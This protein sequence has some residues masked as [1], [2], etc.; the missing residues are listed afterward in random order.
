M[1]NFGKQQAAPT[2]QAAPAQGE[3]ATPPTLDAEGKPIEPAPA[4]K[5]AP[6]YEEITTLDQL[7]FLGQ[8]NENGEGSSAPKALDT[9]KLLT[10]EALGNIASSIDFSSNM[11]PEL[12]DRVKAGD[13]SS[14]FEALQYVGQNAYT[15]SMMHGGLVASKALQSN[16][17]VQSSNLHGQI[18][19]AIN[20]KQ[21]LAAIPGSDNP[22][23]ANA[24]ANLSKQ[25]KAQYP[26]AT[27]DQV[28]MMTQQ[29]FQQLSNAMNP[30]AP[31][32]DPNAPKAKNW[33]E[34][35]GLD[36]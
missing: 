12:V 1:F 21:V 20:D 16:L 18:D 15:Q 28:A 25:V 34:F 31:N 26:N 3:P 23:V 29:S 4:T 14:F 8:N 10:P 2:N 33:L 7:S 30:A 9:D 5:T 19:V 32:T 35:S 6:Q 36:K 24:I 11:P 22:V 13:P 27:A 17:E